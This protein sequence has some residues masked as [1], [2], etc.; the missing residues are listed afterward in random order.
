MVRRQPN[1]PKGLQHRTRRG[2]GFSLIEVLVGVILTSLMLVAGV[3]ALLALIQGDSANQLEL[4]R[5]DAVGRVLGL[6]QDEIRNAQRLDSGTIASPLTGIDSTNCPTAAVRTVLIL[7]GPTA[8]D[9]ISYGLQVRADSTWRG[10][11]VLVR[12]GFPY[13]D[14]GSLNTA[15]GRSEQVVLDNL[16]T[17]GFTVST[18]GGAGAISRTLELTLTTDASGTPVRSTQQV[19]INTAQVY[20]LASSTAGSSG[21]SG[22]SCRTGCPSGI[23]VQWTPEAGDTVEGNYNLEDVIYFTG[24]RSDFEISGVGSG[25]RCINASTADSP[26][27]NCRVRRGSS[28]AWVSI[29]YGDVLVFSDSEIRIPNNPG[30]F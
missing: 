30:I 7:R 8:S 20:D 1:S 5:K 26:A 18:L 17:G 6:M 22:S 27:G 19:P 21:S 28:G 9:D 12:C 14:D 11:A 4:N 15:A 13:R 10:P 29:N 2:D 3:R 25:N 24:N 23:S 16:Q